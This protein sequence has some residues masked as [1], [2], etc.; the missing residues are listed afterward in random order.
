[1]NLVVVILTL[2]FLEQACPP[3]HPDKSIPAQDG[4]G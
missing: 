3:L 2:L 4:A 1:M